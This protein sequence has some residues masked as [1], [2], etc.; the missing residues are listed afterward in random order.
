MNP[1]RRDMTTSLQLR[2][3]SMIHL[4]VAKLK[5]MKLQYEISLVR[6]ALETNNISFSKFRNGDEG[7]EPDVVFERERN[8]QFSEKWASFVYGGKFHVE[9]FYKAESGSEGR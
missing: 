2:L 9:R 4:Y 3:H 7:I 1:T 5:V 8:S 6:K